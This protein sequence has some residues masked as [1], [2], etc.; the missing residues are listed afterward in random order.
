[1]SEQESPLCGF[2][3]CLSHV[4]HFFFIFENNKNIK[5]ALLLFGY[6]HNL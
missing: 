5:Y 1:M 6:M 4:K 3:S 2:K